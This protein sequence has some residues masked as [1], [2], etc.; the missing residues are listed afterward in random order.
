MNGYKAGRLT[1]E[2]AW[3]AQ[4]MFC[5][6]LLDPGEEILAHR[7]C[8]VGHVCLGLNEADA[9]AE[10]SKRRKAENEVKRDG[11]TRPPCDMSSVYPDADAVWGRHP[12]ASVRA[13]PSA[14]DYHR[15]HLPLQRILEREGPR[16][17]GK[18]IA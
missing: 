12:P 1:V 7:H 2:V 16:G 9:I 13:F 17:R 6:E 15:S 11:S 5:A 4:D 8:I 10:V 3:N 18:L 14:L